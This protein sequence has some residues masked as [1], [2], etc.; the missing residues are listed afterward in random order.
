WNRGQAQLVTG[1]D[2]ELADVIHEW[3][4]EPDD[5]TARRLARMLQIHLYREERVVQGPALR[6]P[7]EV[8]EIVLPHSELARL[9]RLI[10]NERGVLRMQII[11]EAR[12]YLK[13]MAARFNG[14]Y[15]GILEFV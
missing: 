14:L 5:R 11:A 7:R 8:R 13:E 1:R 9:T 6:S 15:F 10:A 4:G 2:V 12:V 3:P